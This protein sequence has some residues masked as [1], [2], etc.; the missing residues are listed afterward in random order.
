MNLRPIDLRRKDCRG[1]ALVELAAAV[2]VILVVVLALVDIGIHVSKSVRL[3]PAARAGAL[4]LTPSNNNEGVGVRPTKAIQ[5]IIRAAGAPASINMHRDAQITVSY[6]QLVGVN[7][8]I[9]KQYIKAPNGPADTQ[10]T[11]VYTSKFGVENTNLSEKIPAATLIN[12]SDWIVIVEVFY[13]ASYFTPIP[14]LLKL[15][16]ADTVIYENAIF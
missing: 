14:Q 10:G 12:T 2:V 15:T 11:A 1:Q 5:E 3:A 16:N 6:V 7:P 8:T 4:L 13:K 9:T